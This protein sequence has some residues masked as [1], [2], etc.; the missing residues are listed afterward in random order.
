MAGVA[1][2]TL[3]SCDDGNEGAIYNMPAEE[4]GYSFLTESAGASYGPAY[5]EK[6]YSFKMARNFAG[7]AETLALTCEGANPLFTVPTSVEFKAGETLADVT[8]GIAG[9]E[10]G[11]SYSFTL[12]IDSAKVS[13]LG[14]TKGIA[15]TELTFAVDY[16]WTK[17]GVC[18]VS[19]DWSKNTVEID[20]EYA[21]EYESADVILCRFANMEYMLEPDY[22]DPGYHFQ[23]FLTKGTYDPAGTAA[24]VQ[25][26]GEVSSDDGNL[27]WIYS[28]ASGHT[29]TREYNVYALSGYVGYDSFGSSIS[30][31]WYYNLEF[32]WT[33]GW[34]GDLPEEGGDDE[35]PEEE[36]GNGFGAIVAG[37]TADDYV[38]TYTATFINDG[39]KEGS[40]EVTLTKVN[41]NTVSMTGL[42]GSKY[43]FEDAGLVLD[44]FGGLLYVQ[45]G[46]VIG[47]N[48]Y[49]DEVYEVYAFTYSS[50][51]GYYYDEAMLVGGFKE[52]GDIQF[53]N[54]SYNGEDVVDGIINLFEAM[55]DDEQMHTYLG[56]DYIPCNI[57]LTPAEQAEAPAK[58]IKTVAQSLEEARSFFN[59][60]ATRIMGK[61]SDIRIK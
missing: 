18:E 27:Y 15:K 1:A 7:E 6:T 25:A 21:P 35:E 34:T 26:M 24:T 31:G 44:I 19:D 17:K 55:G 30:P 39:K 4:Q 38:G 28:P 8:I 60:K 37:G 57:V 41:D 33:E 58:S 54:Y 51:T 42:F 43:E 20:L 59:V 9:M 16:S 56:A 40:A 52:N 45:P 50:E 48:K 47:K 53:V 46:Q 36:A 12:G 3:V 23:F 14:E 29:F 32:T 10:T 5:T 11:K 2:F 49:A 22:A 13:S 61:M